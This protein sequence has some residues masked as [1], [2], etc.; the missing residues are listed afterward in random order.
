MKPQIAA[1]DWQPTIAAIRSA[2][3]IALITHRNPDG[4]GIG[5]Q[6]GL[7]HALKQLGK[8]VI[9]HNRD[10]VPRI[11]G[12]LEGA[13]EIGRGNWDETAEQPDVIISLDCG[14]RSRLGMPEA[15]FSGATLINIDHHASNSR[16]GDINVIDAAYCATGAMISDLLIA[17]GIT[18]NAA[19]ARPIYAAILTDTAS[20][21]LNSADAGVY[22]LAA[23]LV[24][25]GAEPWP[26]CME[27]YE[28]RSLAGLRLLSECLATLTLRDD[29]RSAWIY[30][31]HDM[32]GRTGAD[33]E[34]TEGLI[35]YARGMQGVEVAVFIRND[36][37]AD[38]WKLSFR[39]KTTADV[40][41][42]A[43]GLGGG[44]H[45]H[46][47]GC[48]LRGTLSEIEARVQKAVSDLFA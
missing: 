12:F 30:V 23:D 42:L 22:R 47:S 44:G 10:G 15:F 14:S 26:I 36:D 28:S 6:L 31:T 2:R 1:T 9:M 39:G 8:K 27:V 33:V 3:L 4:D 19:M 24:E 41:S 11:Y 43:A 7:Y 16:F 25:A 34:D 18:M 13:A 29:G 37:G 46:A 40:G 32:Y 20:F 35:D 17:L 38:C 5:S 21:R 45:R 48:M